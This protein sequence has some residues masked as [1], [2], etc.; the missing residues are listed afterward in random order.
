MQNYHVVYLSLGSNLGDKLN[1][2]NDASQYIQEDIGLIINSSEVYESPSWGY[3]SLSSFYNVIIKIHT[4]FKAPKLLKRIKK[5]EEKLGRKKNI[6]GYE[7]RIIDIDIIDFNQ[8]ILN[9]ENLIIP[10][11]QMEYRNFVLKPLADIHPNYIHPVSNKTIKQLLEET[12]DKNETIKTD[13]KLDFKTFYFSKLTNFLVI[14][15]NIGAG[16][17][18]LTAKIGQDFNAK[19][20]FERYAENPFLPKFYKDQVRFAFP[21]EMSFL[22]D[23]YQQVTDDLAQFDLFKDFIVSDYHIVKSLIF[24][25]VTLQADEYKLYKSLFDI[26]Y[27][28]IPKPDLYLYLYRQTDNLFENIKKRG[29]TYEKNIKK[30]YLENINQGYLDHINTNVDENILVL[31]VTGK[32]FIKNQ[33]DYLWVIEKINDKLVD[34]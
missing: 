4:H 18:T 5:I 20:V 15:G 12:K 25:K 7:D 6:E 17:T 34:G 10:H 13:K 24:A 32:D 26:I 2:L 1:H 16:K 29:R 33:K 9:L 23:R 14:E 22:A 3:N 19:M 31:D 8:E 11:K 28:D 27:K 30:A 21:L